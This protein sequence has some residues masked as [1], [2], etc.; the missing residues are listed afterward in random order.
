MRNSIPRVVAIHDLSGLG[1]TSL[2]A[3]VPILSCLGIQPVPL[4]TAVLSTQTVGTGEFSFLDLTD[5]MKVMVEH[6]ERRGERFDAVYSGFLAC[7]EQMETVVRC[8]DGL[9]V[10]GGLCVVDP[11]LG[12]DGELIPTM[13]PSMV[14][15]MRS[16]ISR[17]SVITPNYTEVCLLLGE[18]YSARAGIDELKRRLKALSAFGP[19][20]VVGTSM[21]VTELNGE[22]QHCSV[23]A[24]ERAI[25]GFWRVDCDYIPGHFPGTGDV[26]ASI[27]T[28]CLLQGESLSICIDKAVQF[29]TLGVRATYGQDVDPLE[30]ILLERY[31]PTLRQPIS[32]C[33]TRLV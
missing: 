19:E 23:L 25:D 14:E 11:V 13:T 31:L 27:L 21:P 22:P 6:W 15:G 12:E 3:A 24:Y 4:P 26:F 29:T 9:L 8:M 10:P 28:G 16:L 30:G 2:T 17:A 5:N 20:I 33:Q 32:F 18:D 7:P 1:R